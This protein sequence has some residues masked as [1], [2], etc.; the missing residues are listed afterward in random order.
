MPSV[1]LWCFHTGS[2]RLTSSTSSAQVANASL[3]VV[4]GDGTGQRHVPDAQPA[5]PVAHRDRAHAMGARAD[6]G[7]HLGD[8]LLGRGVRAVVQRQHPAAAVVVA[9][10]AGKRDHGAGRRVLH[11]RGVLGDVQR[12]LADGRAEHAG[13]LGSDFAHWWSPPCSWS[14]ACWRT[15]AS[16]AIPSRTPPVDPGG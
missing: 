7:G 9:H 1:K 5:H 3:A 12:L 16:T 15:S 2:C 10:H 11:Q 6:L 4:G 13:P 8:D 14:T